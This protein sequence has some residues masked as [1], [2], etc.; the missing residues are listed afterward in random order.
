MALRAGQFRILGRTAYDQHRGSGP[1]AVPTALSDMQI[2]FRPGNAG[3]LASLC[4]LPLLDQ[5]RRTFRKG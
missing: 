1:M 5:V 2:T 4:N 3:A